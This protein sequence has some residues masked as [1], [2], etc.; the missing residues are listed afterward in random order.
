LIKILLAGK[1]KVSITVYLDK[2][3]FHRAKKLKP[4]LV[5]HPEPELRFF[6]AYSPDLNPVERYGGICAK[7]NPQSLSVIYQRMYR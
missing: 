2:C 1:G 4:F 6:P 7:R 5:A 3:R